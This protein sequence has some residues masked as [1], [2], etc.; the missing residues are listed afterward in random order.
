M[1]GGASSVHRALGCDLLQRVH[2]RALA[3]E[4]QRSG[5]QFARQVPLA[6]RYKGEVVGAYTSDFLIEGVAIVGVKVFKGLTAGHDAR[7]VDYLRAAQC[8]DGLLLDSGATRLGIKRLVH[9]DNEL[10]TI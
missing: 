4:L 6:V 10:D 8:D 9:S 1:T 3:V 2:E 5:V 7:K